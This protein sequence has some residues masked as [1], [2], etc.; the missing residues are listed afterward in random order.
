MMHPSVTNYQ[1][2][3]TIFCFWR[4]AAVPEV[5]GVLWSWMKSRLTAGVIVCRE[6]DP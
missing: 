6:E 1:P 2:N 3:G 4:N 5:R